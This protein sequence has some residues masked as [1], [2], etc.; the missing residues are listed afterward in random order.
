M[1]TVKGRQLLFDNYTWHE[2]VKRVDWDN[3]A[4]S[5][6]QAGV[7]AALASA[8]YTNGTDKPDWK[9]AGEFVRS[10]K[11]DELTKVKDAFEAMQEYKLFV[12]ELNKQKE[13]L[14]PVTK[15][16]PLKPSKKT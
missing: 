1:I 10:F 2:Y 4:G 16:K 11:P 14:V 5:S 13:S 9:E 6:N 15:K 3:M 12:E 7:Y 8:A